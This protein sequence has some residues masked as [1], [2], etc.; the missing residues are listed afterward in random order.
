MELHDEILLTNKNTPA[1]RNRY[2]YYPDHLVRMPG[3]DPQAGFLQNAFS[4]LR[5]LLFEPVFENFLKGVI[6]EPLKVDFTAG[7]PDESVAE[8]VARRLNP[9][10]AD[11]LVS[12]FV[13][14]VY[15]GDIDKL[16]AQALFG[17]IRTFESPERGVIGSLLH[18][19]SSGRTIVRVDDS[20]VRRAV[21]T[22]KPPE[23]W[24]LLKTLV[25]T[26]SALTFKN[27][28]GQLSDALAAA[29]DKHDK[30]EVIANA[31]VRAISQIPES[32]DLIV[33]GPS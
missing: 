1:A 11:N 19:R 10:V 31:N 7:P 2:L 21:G 6:T 27:G 3:P 16:S 9:D 14:G 22:S 8:F 15:A 33:S 29:L 20:L 5:T 13:H 30:V 4:N 28:V 32:S 24:D 18:L 17:G 25:P 26:S 23:Y 12:A